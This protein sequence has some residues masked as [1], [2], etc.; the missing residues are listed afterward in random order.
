MNST[1][2]KMA[3]YEFINSFFSLCD[4]LQQTRMTK[5]YYSDLNSD[6]HK[7]SISYLLC[8]ERDARISDNQK[9]LSL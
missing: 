8:T 3:S 1:I 5:T 7:R 4:S 9:V 2:N 6:S